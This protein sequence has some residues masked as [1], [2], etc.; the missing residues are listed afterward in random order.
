MSYQLTDHNTKCLIILFP[1]LKCLLECCCFRTPLAGCLFCCLACLTMFCHQ[2]YGTQTTF[3]TN[4][5]ESII[6]HG[7]LFGSLARMIYGSYNSDIPTKM[8]LCYR[9]TTSWNNLWVSFD[10]RSKQAVKA[11]IVKF[12]FDGATQDCPSSP[13][14]T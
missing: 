1:V 2:V 12:K 10:P 13:K 14:A 11:M 3:S 4:V 5:P 8:E 9:A 7:R 6:S